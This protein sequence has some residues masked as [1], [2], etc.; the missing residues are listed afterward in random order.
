MDHP[1]RCVRNSGLNWNKVQDIRDE[2]LLRKSHQALCSISAKDEQ[3]KSLS[4]EFCEINS[5]SPSHKT[6]GNYHLS[7]LPTA[8]CAKQNQIISPSLLPCEISGRTNKHN[9]II[10]NLH[11]CARAGKPR[12]AEAHL[13]TMHSLYWKGHEHLKPDVRHFNSILNAW[14]KSKETGKEFRTEEILAWMYQLQETTNYDVKPTRVSFNICISAWSK[15]KELDAGSRALKLFD[16]MSSLYEAGDSDLKPDFQSYRSVICALSKNVIKGSAPKA[17]AILQKMRLSD[18]PETSPDSSL[19]HMVIH[20]Y[21]NNRDVNAPERAEALLNEMHFAF[22]NGNIAVKP[23]TIT[24]NT[25]LNTYA[26]SLTQGLAERAESIL[27]RMKELHEHGYPNVEPDTITFNSV[28]NAHA[29]SRSEGSAV[30]VFGILSEMQESYQ[31][32]IKKA[33]PDT[34]TYNACLKACYYSSYV[35]NK[36]SSA[37]INFDVACK[38]LSQIH[39]ELD[40]QPD[41]HTFIWFFRACKAN[42]Y[43]ESKH[44]QAVEWAI[45][46]CWK[47]GLWTDR[48]IKEYQASGDGKQH[49]NVGIGGLPLQLGLIKS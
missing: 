49:G 20:M 17:E 3:E 38:L 8:I 1:N 18:D 35:I 28:I 30:R 19:Y 10:K 44:N 6:S 23:N 45:Q 27:R 39:Y 34:R 29:N 36:E 14:A 41:E 5:W 12:D 7:E 47:A 16:Y 40:S 25:V 46:L 15:S 42:Y 24:F 32:G 26:K 9:N 21:S 11:E 43:E 2:F 48:V 13:Q 4:L 31:N 33:K 22:M 37:N